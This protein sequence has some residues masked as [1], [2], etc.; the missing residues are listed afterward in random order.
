VLIGEGEVYEVRI[1]VLRE[2]DPDPT[3]QMILGSSQIEHLEA[4]GTSLFM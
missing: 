3:V 1:G 4:K 2:I